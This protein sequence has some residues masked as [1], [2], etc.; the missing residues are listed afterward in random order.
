VQCD[1][2]ESLNGEHTYFFAWC[3]A[4]VA[5]HADLPGS[6]MSTAD[7]AG[8]AEKAMSPLREAVTLGNRNPNTYQFESALDPLR[9]RP[10]F[11]VLMMDLVMPAKPFAR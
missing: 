10:D 7:G 2:N 1:A 8:Q 11:R 4:G 3:H 9:N 5:E 6:R